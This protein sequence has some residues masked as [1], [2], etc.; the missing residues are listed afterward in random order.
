MKIDLIITLVMMGLIS[1]IAGKISYE[2]Y[3]SVNGYLRKIL[4]WLFGSISWFGLWSLL[5]LT[6]YYAWHVT[7]VSPGI[8]RIIF[9][10][11]LFVSMLF[12]LDYLIKRKK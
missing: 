7:I 9:F 1:I 2:F 6:G 4:V 5:Y 10:T 3:R 12:M 11:P 8:S